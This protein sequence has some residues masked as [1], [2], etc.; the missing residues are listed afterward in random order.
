MKP[1]H[2]CA[3]AVA[4]IGLA[5]NLFFVGLFVSAHQWRADSLVRFTEQG[6]FTHYADHTLGLH[7][8]TSGAGHDGQRFWLQARDPFVLH[9]H[10][11]DD[12]DSRPV[13][14]N[15]R[16]LYPLLAAPWRLAGE[17]ALFVGLVAVNLGAVAV[18]TFFAARLSIRVAATA[19]GGLA[20][21][22]NPLVLLSTMLDLADGL[23]FAGLIATLFFVRDRRIRWAILAATLAVL[24]KETALLGL[25]GL[26]LASSQYL[27]RRDRLLLFAVP[28]SIAAAWGIYVRS[29]FGWP[30]VQQVEFTK[31]PFGGWIYT[32][33]KGWMVYGNWN[34]AFVGFVSL[35][36]AV[37]VVVR[38]LN[39]R[40]LE[41]AT[42]VPM[43]LLLPFMTDEVLFR[44][45]NSIRVVGAALTL[46][47]IDRLAEVR[48]SRETG[49]TPS[50]DQ[51]AA[52]VPHATQSSG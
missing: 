26:C 10:V 29:R 2:R 37:V 46:L 25:L 33:H 12:L 17:Q 51:P 6:S 21:A 16:L 1:E 24:A 18:G 3:I 52:P 11:W 43:V 9:P 36:V 5:V 34:D 32:L 22:L 13:Y 23:S 27:R 49:P 35:V 48:V 45:E 42:A 20:F 50:T 30:T 47:V 31:V 39:R 41:L 4:A 7:V 28:A 19:L 38:F 40:T 8:L 44:G 15:Q 14:R